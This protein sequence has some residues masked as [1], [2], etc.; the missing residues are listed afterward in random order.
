MKLKYTKLQ[1]ALEIIGILVITGMIIFVCVRFNQLP[2]KIP[3]HYNAMGEVNRWG[4]KREI[5]TVPIVSIILYA[6]ITVITFFPQIWNVSVQITNENKEAVYRCVRSL[7]ILTKIEMLGTFFYLTIFMGYSKQLPMTFLPVML[8][9]IFGTI[10]F[11]IIRILKIG[12]E[13]T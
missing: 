6:F 3:G 11:F 1:I 2:E 9:I 4:N 13:K 5:F 10:I 12:K 7:I 8:L